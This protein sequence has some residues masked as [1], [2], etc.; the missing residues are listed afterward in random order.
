[1]G[2]GVYTYETN[3]TSGDEERHASNGNETELPR[4]DETNGGTSDKSRNTL[5]DTV[6]EQ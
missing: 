4:E 6:K 2:E 3:V 5:N 1:M